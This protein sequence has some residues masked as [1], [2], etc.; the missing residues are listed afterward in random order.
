MII[1]SLASISGSGSTKKTW[2][3]ITSSN[4]S[5]VRVGDEIACG[6]SSGSFVGIVTYRASSYFY[7]TGIGISSNKKFEGVCVLY[8]SLSS[9]TTT[10][11]LTG[12]EG[13][14]GTTQPSSQT[15]SLT[16]AIYTSADLSSR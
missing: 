14:Y 16:D 4:V 6:S 15:Y 1:N 13:G 3:S 9:S 10:K 8:V 12:I 5:K 7:A 11:S 2:T